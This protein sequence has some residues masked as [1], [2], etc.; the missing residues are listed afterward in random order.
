MSRN[1][2]RSNDDWMELITEC[3]RSGLSDV[4]WCEQH[5][6]PKST[7][8]NAVTRL[9]K[10]ACDIPPAVPVPAALDLT[11]RQEAVRIDIVA[12]EAADELPVSRKSAVLNPVPCHTGPD[13]HLDNSHMIEIIFQN[14]RVLIQNGTDP[15]LLRTAVLAAGSLSC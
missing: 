3:R 15:E 14:A 6:I 10:L 13:V 8:Y 4:A 1:N 11:N 9:R 12:D 2:P 7:F 5:D